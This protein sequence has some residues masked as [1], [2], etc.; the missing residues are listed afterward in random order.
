[1]GDEQDRLATWGEI[2][3]FLNCNVRTAQRWA[4]ERGLPVRRVPG[5]QKSSVFAYRRELQEWL[6]RDRTPPMPTPPGPRFPITRR[7]AIA[8]ASVGAAITGSAVWAW[9]RKPRDVTRAALVGNTLVAWD[10]MGGMLWNHP[11]SETFDPQQPPPPPRNP[12]VCDL[13]SE[14][15]NQVLFIG[16]FLEPDGLTP[17]CELF[18]FSSQGQML[19]HYRPQLSLT[20]GNQPFSGPWT[21]EDIMFLNS[22]KGPRIWVALS[23]VTWRPGAL[24]SIDA[25]GRHSLQ[26]ASCGNI[27]VLSQMANANGQYILAGGI[28]NEY[29][30][31]AL[32]VVRAE[33]PPSSSPQTKGTLY[34]CVNGPSG[35]PELYFL[36]PPTELNSADGKPYNEILRVLG[37]SN[38]VDVRTQEA[39]RFRVQSLAEAMYAISPS[40]EV[41]NVAFD[42]NFAV[43]HRRFEQAGLLKHSLAACP[44]LNGPSRIRRWDA[45]SGWTD[46]EVPMKSGVRPE[47]YSG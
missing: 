16:R 23:H 38:G 7:G 19:W 9:R 43:Q 25:L 2:A 3:K 5:G 44:L 12:L 28:N 35:K 18:C 11:F 39:G 45:A 14:G 6:D 29:N 22:P 4:N 34:E 26:F 13:L 33:G 1:M 47:S 40:L 8:M 32:A 10:A 21:I 37:G 31:A 36:F 41:Q 30:A 17:R 24:V 46:V 27:Y 20:F 42:N 15:N